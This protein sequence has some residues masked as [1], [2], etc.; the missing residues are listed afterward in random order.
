[1]PTKKKSAASK[2]SK[3][4]TKAQKKAPKKTNSD[5]YDSSSITVL[6]GLRRSK[7]GLVCI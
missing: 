6:K 1:M 4:P 2:T 3:A 7:K 5:S